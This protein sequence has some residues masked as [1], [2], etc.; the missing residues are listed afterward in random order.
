MRYKCANRYQKRAH[1]HG[2]DRCFHEKSASILFDFPLGVL[3]TV[4]LGQRSSTDFPLFICFIHHE[5]KTNS[6]NVSGN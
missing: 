4:V 5:E 6:T 3:C 1:L 2:M